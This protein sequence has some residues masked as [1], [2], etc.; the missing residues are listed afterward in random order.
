MKNNINTKYE[1]MGFVESLI[2]IMI[3]GISSVV[4]LQIAANTTQS[5]LQN[6]TIDIMTQ[7]AVEGSTM[8]QNIAM[9]QRLGGATDIF[10]TT[11][12]CYAIDDDATS[13]YVFRKANGIF[14]Q[15][16]KDTDRNEYKVST[17]LA[18]NSSFF[19]IFCLEGYSSGDKYAIVRIIVGQTNSEGLITKGSNVKDYSYFTVA[20]L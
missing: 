16:T 9:Q 18:S 12:G 13:Q 11:D 10:P 20:Q 15:Y 6:E 8:V 1:G 17:V 14:T 5:M 19:R 7:Y 3:V 2:A 4:L